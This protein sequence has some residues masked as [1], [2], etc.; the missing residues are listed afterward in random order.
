MPI[1]HDGP[2]WRTRAEEFRVLAERLTDPEARASIL[3][4]AEEY[5]KLAKRAETRVPATI[6]S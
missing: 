5:D 2:H 1:L 4:I 6:R 3:R